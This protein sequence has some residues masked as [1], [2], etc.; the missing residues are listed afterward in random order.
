[1]ALEGEGG[2]CQRYAPVT[3]P[4]GKRSCTHCT[5]SWV[6]LG[7]SLGESRIS[8]PHQGSNPGSSSP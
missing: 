7:A 4:Q 8:R 6:G 2:G 1:L 3:F 5:G